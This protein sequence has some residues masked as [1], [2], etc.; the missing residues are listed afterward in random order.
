MRRWLAVLVFLAFVVVSSA[1]ARSDAS[2]KFTVTSS[3]DGKKVLPLR[4]RWIA[5]PHTALPNIAEV[6]FLIDGQAA[7]TAHQ[8]PY[9]YGAIEG[10]CNRLVT[11][12]LT[13]GV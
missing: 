5:N 11:S 13:P 8:P 2:S 4:I 6:V 10:V 3:L 1:L 9:C 7:W 12:F